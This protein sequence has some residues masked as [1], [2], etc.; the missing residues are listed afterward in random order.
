MQEVPSRSKSPAW[1]GITNSYTSPTKP[2]P[3]WTGFC[4]VCSRTS[5]KTG[6][7][8]V[9]APVHQTIQLLSRHENPVVDTRY[10]KLLADILTHSN[11]AREGDHSR[12]LAPW[13]VPLLNRIPIAPIILC[14]LELASADDRFD[15]AQYK[16]FARCVS[17]LWPLAVPKFSPETLLECFGAL[18]HLSLSPVLSSSDRSWGNLQALDEYRASSSVVASYRSSLAASTSKRKVRNEGATSAKRGIWLTKALA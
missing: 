3:S 15:V 12:A 2:R 13:L 8:G 6:E 14:Y 4:P 18:V 16:L 9:F 10:W 1:R 5:R 11:P 17:I 7:A